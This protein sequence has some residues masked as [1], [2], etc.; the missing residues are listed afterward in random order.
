MDVPLSVP[1]VL[2][3]HNQAYFSKRTLAVLTMFFIKLDMFFTDPINYTGGEH[4]VRECLLAEHSLTTMWNWLRGADGTTRLDALRMWVKHSYK[5]PPRPGPETK[6]TQKILDERAQLPIMN[7]P[8]NMVGRWGYELRGKGDQRLIRPDELVLRESVRRKMDL[9]K[10][11]LRMVRWG[12]VG[13]DLETMPEVKA[14]DTVLS[15]MKR[16]R[17]QAKAKKE[18]KEQLVRPRE[19]MDMGDGS[20]DEDPLHDLEMLAE[21]IESERT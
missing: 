17:N 18:M 21:Q 1:R 12:F 6:E 16:K 11:W 10:Q 5:R 8:A 15:M 14:E 13:L 3:I 7:I 19:D 4:V 2:L 20:D 9:Q